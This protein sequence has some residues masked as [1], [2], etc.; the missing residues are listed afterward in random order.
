[1]SSSSSRSSAGGS[2]RTSF[3]ASSSS[4]SAGSS[5]LQTSPSFTGF[6]PSQPSGSAGS[7]HPMCDG[8][9]GCSPPPATLYLYTFL[10]TLIILLMVSG[11][12]ITRS[13][14]LRRR[15]QIAI[16]NGTWDNPHRRENYS[17]RPRPVMFDAYVAT[18]TGGKNEKEEE[19]WASMKPFSASDCAPPAKPKPPVESGEASGHPPIRHTARDQLR[20]S[21]VRASA[22][23][24]PPAIELESQPDLIPSKVRVAFLVAMPWQGVSP[25]NEEEE[26]EEV[27]YLEF[28]VLTLI[29]GESERPDLGTKS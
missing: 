9:G 25:K 23:P 21:L 11:G 26:E 28:G 2:S 18:D 14:V 12:I 7:Q 16:A 5:G 29:G 4:S 10:S 6:P 24:P 15:Q 8:P 13:V 27:P 17:N 1:M 19:R 22:P 20:R 3:V